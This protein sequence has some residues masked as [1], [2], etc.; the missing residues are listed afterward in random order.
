MA[1]DWITPKEDAGDW[2]PLPLIGA[3]AAS[4]PTLILISYPIYINLQGI[5]P[6]L[7]PGSIIVAIVAALYGGAAGRLIPRFGI[8]KALAIPIIPAFLL[9]FGLFSVLTRGQ[10]LEFTIIVL[11]ASVVVAWLAFW[12]WARKHPTLGGPSS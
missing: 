10:S 9:V 12:L 3:V 6:G 2:W 8:P 4:L 7:P 1:D 11:V 5:G